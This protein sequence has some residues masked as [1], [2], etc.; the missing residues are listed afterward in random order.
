[1]VRTSIKCPS[2]GRKGGI[3]SYPAWN[4]PPIGTKRKLDERRKC[5]ACKH[6]WWKS[7]VTATASK[8]KGKGKGKTAKTA[9]AV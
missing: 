8:G 9:V 5:T 1:M 2:C 4:Y 6:Q 3:V 7:E